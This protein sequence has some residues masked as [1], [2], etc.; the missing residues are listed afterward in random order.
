MRLYTCTGAPSP[1][2]VTLYLAEKGLEIETVEVDL[3]AGEHLC[4]DFENKSPECTV[5]VLELDDGTCL[6]NTI[7]I[8]EYLESQHPEPPL[9]GGEVRQRALV[10]QWVMWVE[11]HGFQAAAEAFR[12][13]AEG[14]KDHAL[15]GRRAIPQIAELA[16]RGRT[17][18]GH[19]LED[20]DARLAGEQWVAGDAFSVADIDALVA[21][22]FG[23]RAIK[24]G[25]DEHEHLSAWYEK[26]NARPAIRDAGG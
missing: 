1:R 6:W 20:L 14:M 16:K 18:F 13:A 4:D 7:A 11:G 19:Y 10:T 21:I 25:F 15:P 17:R 3:R 24:R 9:L 22:D 8:R 5:P 2:R 26:V 23:C 12:N